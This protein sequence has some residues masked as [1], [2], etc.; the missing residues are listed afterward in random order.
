VSE[1]QRQGAPPALEH[2]QSLLRRLSTEMVRMQKHAFG[3]GPI[4]AKAYMFDDLLMVVMRDGL[5]VAEKTMLDF[6]QA[7][8]VRNFR[9]QFEND[10]T[11]RMIEPIERLT[12]RKVLTYQ[13][14]IMFD[15]D[16][17]VEIFVFDEAGGY[18]ER[19]ATAEGQ[20]D[21]DGIVGD[22]PGFTD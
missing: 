22:D 21:D 12:G 16:V 10:M 11:S 7:D 2:G 13:S 20:M 6:G 5:T 4:H 18:E 1:Q 15:P 17:I 3:K 8:L 19:F 14:Q 9:Q